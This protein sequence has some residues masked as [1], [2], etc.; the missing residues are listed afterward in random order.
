MTGRT[1]SRTWVHNCP[2]P[3]LPSS[4]HA[5][6]LLVNDEVVATAEGDDWLAA[7]H[8][9]REV[10][11]ARGIPVEGTVLATEMFERLFQHRQSTRP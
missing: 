2:G 4:R 11:R 7:A 3:G 10:L 6:T 9:L 5:A 1:I 8:N